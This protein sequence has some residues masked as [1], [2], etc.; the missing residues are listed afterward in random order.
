MDIP[1]LSLPNS[2]RV[3]F[4]WSYRKP[5]NIEITDAKNDNYI[6][7]VNWL[8]KISD[9]CIWNECLDH[10]VL[11]YKFYSVNNILINVKFLNN[12]PTLDCYVGAIITTCNNNP[13][14]PFLNPTAPQVHNKTLLPRNSATNIVLECNIN[15]LYGVPFY[16]PFPDN[17][18][19]L[20]CNSDRPNALAKLCIFVH[21]GNIFVNCSQIPLV[22]ID[23]SANLDVTL[24][25][26]NK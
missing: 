23:I 26:D 1:Q 15:T 17:Q 11:H 14:N 4:E 24:S 9:I 3:I 25:K 2:N 6:F 18:S 7:Y 16:T 13:V 22:D 12:S 20:K 10:W 19:A 8:N 21:P 5:F